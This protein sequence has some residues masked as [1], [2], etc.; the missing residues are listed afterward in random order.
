[1]QLD[2]EDMQGSNVNS[3]YLSVTR[4]LKYPDSFICFYCVQKAYL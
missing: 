3:K 1:M 2:K 4:L